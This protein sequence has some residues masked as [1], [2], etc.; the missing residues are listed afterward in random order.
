M[1]RTDF[2]YLEE[3]SYKIVANS[4][5][6]VIGNI[7]YDITKDAS[8]PEKGITSK[9]TSSIKIE[10]TLTKY[11]MDLGINQSLETMATGDMYNIDDFTLRLHMINEYKN[12]EYSEKTVSTGT[13]FYNA[14][15]D[16]GSSES[17]SIT[18]NGLFGNLPI[19]SLPSLP[20]ENGSEQS[21]ESAFKDLNELFKNGLGSSDLG[22]GPEIQGELPDFEEATE[23]LQNLQNMPSIL[24]GTIGKY[25]R[26]QIKHGQKSFEVFPSIP[27]NIF[28]DK[29]VSHDYEYIYKDSE[30]K[31]KRETKTYID[32]YPGTEILPFWFL[33]PDYNP[34]DTAGLD[35]YKA[36][37]ENPSLALDSFEDTKDIQ[38]MIIELNNR[39]NR[40]NIFSLIS[41]PGVK[42]GVDV[43]LMNSN[44]E[45]GDFYENAM[46]NG[47]MFEGTLEGDFVS[48][49]GNKYSVKI[50]FNY[51]FVD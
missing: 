25:K 10:E 14:E 22:M 4:P 27:N 1:F 44:M 46:F 30:G 49:K 38:D 8:N 28:T 47:E 5:K 42:R 40:L 17:G 19:P 48:K 23:A 29:W 2:N 6:K 37:N 7:T 34:K 26:F 32:V 36:M 16:S 50:K 24:G 21:I 12:K 11:E 3:L 41:D 43:E 15:N 20:S 39:F 45:S 13:F 18:D 9:V 31:T 33:N 51:Q 35:Q